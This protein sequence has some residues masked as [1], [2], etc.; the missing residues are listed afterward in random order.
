MNRSG[1]R[2]VKNG[3]TEENLNWVRSNEFVSEE[4]I[5]EMFHEFGR[6]WDVVNEVVEKFGG[7]DVVQ[8]VEESLE[9]LRR[10]EKLL[11]KLGKGLAEK[12]LKEL[13]EGVDRDES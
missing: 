2:V 12:R 1:C 10:E 5:L 3:L 7:E 9:Y 4:K 13:A 8:S 6:D 11:K